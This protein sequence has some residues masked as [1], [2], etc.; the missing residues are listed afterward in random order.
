MTTCCGIDLRLGPVAPIKLVLTPDPI[1]LDLSQASPIKLN[2]VAAPVK[3]TVAPQPIKLVVS[4]VGVQGAPGAAWR[5]GDGS[6]SNTLGIDGDF[7]LDNL[8]GDVYQKA[9]GVY[10]VVTNITG[11]TG[12]PGAKGDKGDKGDTGAPGPNAITSATTTTFNGLIAGDGVN[13]RLA[14]AGTDYVAPSAI[15]DTAH[16]GLGAD[17]SAASGV[18]IA[19]AGVFSFLDYLNQSVKTTSSPAFTGLTLSGLTAGSVAFAGAGGVISQKNSNLFWDNTNNRLGIGTNT[20][21]TDFDIKHNYNGITNFQMS[22]QTDGTASVARGQ[23]NSVNGGLV[24][25]AAAPSYTGVTEFAN[26]VGFYST[27]SGTPVTGIVICSST[28]TGIIEF[29]TGGLAASN[30]RL[31]LSASGNFLF[32]TTTTPT[33]ATFNQVLGGGPTSPQLPTSGTADIVSKA[34]CDTAAGDRNEYSINE[35][36]E[37]ERITGCRPRVTTDFARTSTVTLANVPG[38]TRN[39]EAGR[40]YSFRAVLDTSSNTGGGVKVAIGGTCTAT[41][42]W[43]R[44]VVTEGLAIVAHDRATA[45]GTAVG[46]V[47]AVAS[48]LI[49]IEGE[50]VI[51]AAGTLTV[52]FAQNASNGAASTVLTGSHFEIKSL[53]A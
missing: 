30:K 20:P 22:N 40:K 24:C 19:S 23:I 51:N 48:A 8:T 12:S 10:S 16:G 21:A 29:Y 35:Q 27:V 14:V 15:I 44:A 11:P 18:P 41:H 25:F 3:L 49:V 45:L 50:I 43:Y 17:N 38:L 52:Q 31:T 1:R 26:K 32:G 5:N 7:Y 2:V 9:A 39:V 47:T 46:G 33:G 53:A 37:I 6:P 42:I 36:G 4:G 34:A 13:A 28:S